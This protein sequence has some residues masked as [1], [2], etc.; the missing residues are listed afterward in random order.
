[1]II[2][3]LGALDSIE[4]E[5]YLDVCSISNLE[6]HLKSRFDPPEVDSFIYPSSGETGNYGNTSSVPQDDR[7]VYWS[8]PLVTDVRS[9]STM[10]SDTPILDK[11]QP[12]SARVV[13]LQWGIKT[14][15]RLLE[16][17]VYDWP[18]NPV[19]TPTSCVTTKA[20][21]EPHGPHDSPGSGCP[22]PR[23]SVISGRLFSNQKSQ[24]APIVS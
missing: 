3:G 21:L 17:H 19:P 13:I 10:V 23:Q 7:T 16:T 9:A 5:Q 4:F 18:S 1:M 15:E 2:L 20:L 24:I 14:V 22:L 12:S 8:A 11:L 6:P